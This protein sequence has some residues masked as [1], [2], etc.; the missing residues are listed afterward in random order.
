ML[1]SCVLKLVGDF[2]KFLC[3]IFDYCIDRN[4]EMKER[5]LVF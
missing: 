4:K 1:G 2:F 3:E 5:L